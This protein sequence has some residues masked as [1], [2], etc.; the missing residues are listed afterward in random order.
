MLL[1]DV[2]KTTRTGLCQVIVETTG[3]YAMV[4][5]ACVIDEEGGSLLHSR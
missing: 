1:H 3:T 4:A 5:V 2:M